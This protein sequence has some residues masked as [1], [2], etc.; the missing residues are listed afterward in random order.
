MTERKKFYTNPNDYGKQGI[1]YQSDNQF[2]EFSASDEKKM[3][4]D[5]DRAIS[6]FEEKLKNKFGICFETATLNEKGKFSVIE[7]SSGWQFSGFLAEDPES[8]Y[9]L[10]R[11]IEEK[12]PDLH[13]SF[14]E[15]R[16]ALKF[17]YRVSKN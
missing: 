10:A 17:T 2:E 15:D 5:V 4:S 1:F 7:I 11:Q 14:E 8:F 9:K 16:S 12:R 6:Y 3:Q 13:F